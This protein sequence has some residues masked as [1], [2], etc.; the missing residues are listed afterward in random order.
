MGKT[1]RAFLTPINFRQRVVYSLGLILLANFILIWHGVV[2]GNYGLWFSS[3]HQ[4]T[5][6]TSAFMLV[7]SFILNVPDE[8]NRIMLG[9]RTAAAAIVSHGFVAMIQALTGEQYLPRFV[10][11]VTL[12]TWP[13][14]ALSFRFLFQELTTKYT[15]TVWALLDPQNRARLEAAV[16]PNVGSGRIT[17]FKLCSESDVE[18]GISRDDLPDLVVYDSRSPATDT[19]RQQLL[20]LRNRGVRIRSISDFYEDI[21]DRVSL[22]D[23]EL[24]E[25]VSDIREIHS[26]PYKRLS[27][28]I[29]V[30]TGLVLGSALVS[31][32]PFIWICNLFKNKGPL[33][34]RQPRIGQGGREFEILKFRTMT[35]STSAANW[36]STMDPR[37]TPF[38]RLLRVSHLD[39]LPQAINIIRGEL[40]IVGPRPEQPRYVEL[41]RDEIP[42]YE[43]RHVV[44]PGLTGWAQVNFPYGASVEDARHKLQY[45]LYYVRHQSLGLDLRIL[46]LTIRQVL[47][48]R[49]R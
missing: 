9:V 29:D 28:V 45:D 14:Y 24:S 23:I 25:L 41:L 36:T 22:D 44:R 38:G 13:S 30:I 8:P 11:V 5:L 2:Y 31:L 27:R 47:G 32:I 18:L 17:A 1:E 21:L 16:A 7:V 37:V 20:L 33:F 42:Y 10:V 4:W 39:E 12:I 15:F 3:Q 19:V 35:L 46:A 40:A 43:Q 48:L 6:A 26:V 34:Y 49:G